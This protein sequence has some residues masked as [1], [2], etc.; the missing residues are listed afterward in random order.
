MPPALKPG[1][2]SSDDAWNAALQ[3]GLIKVA[4]NSKSLAVS[5]VAF[6]DPAPDSSDSSGYHFVP[7]A[8]LGM[9]DGR[10]ANIPWLQEAPDQISKVVWDSWAEIHPKTAEKL[11]IK[12]GS[13]INVESEHGTLKVQAVVIKSIHPDVIAIPMGQGHEEYGRYAKNRGV[14][15]M[16]LLNPVREEKTGELAMY[17]TRVKVSPTGQSQVVVRMGSSDT[18]AGRKLVATIPVEQ[19]QRT[20]GA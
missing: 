19:Y 6:S 2:L 12:Q 15:P 8:R 10:H 16:K 17:A 13:I 20:E 1:N 4:N 7:S 18:Q 14:N 9:W 3:K 5:S 11:G